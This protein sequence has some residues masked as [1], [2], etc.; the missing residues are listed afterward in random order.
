M[1][2][3]SFSKIQFLRVRAKEKGK[4]KTKQKKN[5]MR[6]SF[7]EIQVLG[8]KSMGFF[9]E[10]KSELS[11]ETKWV[12]IEGRSRRENKSKRDFFFPPRI[13]AEH[14]GRLGHYDL[15]LSYDLTPTLLILM[16]DSFYYLIISLISID[17]FINCHTCFT[18][19]SIDSF[20]G[21]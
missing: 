18:L 7:S 12:P 2:K 10:K 16:H 11:W 15:L 4:K 3:R 21:A 19:F 13:E 1:D 5:R 9:K 20:L 14:Q 8:S 17:F 6:G